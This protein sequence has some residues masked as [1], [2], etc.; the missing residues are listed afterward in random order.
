MSLSFLKGIEQITCINFVSVI[1]GEDNSYILNKLPCTENMVV[2]CCMLRKRLSSNHSYL[3]NSATRV[4]VG[5]KAQE[6]DFY[7]IT[8][9]TMVEYFC[10]HL[11]DNYVDLSDLYVDLSD[12]YVDL[13]KN[14]FTTS[15]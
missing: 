13:S 11:S 4:L 12:I 5:Q 15:S 6:K 14:I 7:Q 2:F 10:H 3:F 9:D 1:F 8:R